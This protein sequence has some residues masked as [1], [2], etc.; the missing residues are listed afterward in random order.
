[1][2]TFIVLGAFFIAGANVA[3]AGMA[4]FLPA[5][6]AVSS[7]QLPDYQVNRMLKGDRLKMEPSPVAVEPQQPV[8]RPVEMYEGCEPSTSTI[9]NTPSAHRSARCVT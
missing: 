2:K 1:M 4:Y 8:T 9:L 3:A 7:P 6:A 5:P